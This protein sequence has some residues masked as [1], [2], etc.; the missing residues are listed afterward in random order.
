MVLILIIGILLVGTAVALI[1]RAL[2]LPRLRTSER[3][4][5][6]GAYSFEAAQVAAPAPLTE[7][8]PRTELD[9]RRRIGALA[10]SVGGRLEGRVPG[11]GSA[12]LRRRL[13]AAG[14]YSTPPARFVGYQVLA[15]VLLPALWLWITLN[16][17]TKPVLIL[18]GTIFCT[19]LGWYVPLSVVRRKAERRLAQIDYEMPELIDT[20]VTTVEA[21]IAFAASMQIA[22]RRFRGP[23]AEELR[24]TLQEQNMG[25][26]VRE[27]LT[28][29]LDRCDTPAIRSFV[30]SI[31]QGEVLGVSMGHTL[32]NL[33]MEMRKRRR[34]AAEE[35][36][37]KAPVKMLF[38]LVFLIFPSMF[39]VLL[40]PALLS[41]DKLFGE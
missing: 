5:Q 16:A 10:T 4:T 20:L 19:L 21:G 30:R 40:G 38:P 11:P 6:I 1:G 23:L 9:L 18:L 12:E 32:R 8:S 22:A 29:L 31:V 34:Q 25:L 14:L 27:S 13:I 24:L 26:G 33:A 36:A 28:N 3:L 41:L 39:I 2:V 35:R 37:Q 17:G 7:P 15:T